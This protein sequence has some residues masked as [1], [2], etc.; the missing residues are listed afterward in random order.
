VHEMTAK[1]FGDLKKHGWRHPPDYGYG[2]YP[3]D[4]R[5]AR[6]LVNRND[7]AHVRHFEDVHGIPYDENDPASFGWMADAKAGALRAANYAHAA[8]KSGANMVARNAVVAGN[9]GSEIGGRVAASAARNAVATGN[10]GAELGGRLAAS[11]ARNALQAKND[12]Q[13]TVH[14]MTAKQFGDLKKHGWRHP[15]DYGYGNYPGDHRRRDSRLRWIR[16]RAARRNYRQIFFHI[17]LNVIRRRNP[18]LTYFVRN[19]MQHFVHLCEHMQ[20]Q[21]ALS[22]RT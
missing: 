20:R 7:R 1:Q 3:G 17:I 22:C 21:L 2:N 6:A 9:V 12:L 10:V 11:T 14:E 4:H 8:G 13:A 19:H 16:H 18:C 5:D 15:P